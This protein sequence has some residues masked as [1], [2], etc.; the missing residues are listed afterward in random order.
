MVRP[1]RRAF[2]Q[3]RP[4][5]GAPLGDRRLVALG[6]ALA[7]LLRCPL[8]RL[9]QAR[10]VSPV[11]RDRELLP[12]KFGDAGAG[13][14]L[15]AEAEGF[16]PVREQPRYQ[17]ALGSGEPGGGPEVRA[18]GESP[19]PLRAHEAHPLANGGG[20]D[21]EGFGDLLLPPAPSSKCQRAPSSEF[22]PIG[23]A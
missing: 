6:G 10:D 18:G 3:R 21:S 9:E 23:W 13:P 12:D 16:G 4:P 14:D 5:L 22:F 8:Q 11:V 17:R 7:R 15:A 19:L 1:S 2:F 20:R